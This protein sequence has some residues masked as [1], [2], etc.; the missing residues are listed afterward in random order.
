MA[1]V[2]TERLDGILLITLNRP[3]VRNAVNAALARGVADAL[4]ELD[5]DDSLRVGIL[6]GAGGTFCSG[7]DLG[8]LLQGDNPRIEGRGF[9]GVV[10][11]G[12]VK[13]LIA[14]VEGYAVAGGFEVALACDIIV[15]GRGAKFGL[16][17]VRRGLTPAGGGVL[18]LPQRL[19]YYVAMEL[20]FTGN[21]I[22][23]DRA[24]SFGLVSDLVETGGAV[25]RAVEI[26]RQIVAN[27]PLSVRAIK[28]IVAA[29]PDWPT[30]RAFELQSPITSA[31]SASDDARE[32]ARAF[33][34]KRPAVWTGR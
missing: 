9:A 12:S 20:L 34:E 25:D 23:A 31:V 4:D 18:R 7:M 3:E 10:Q 1:E 8:A 2:E 27:A 24:Y 33:K 30:D 19:P 11:R 29:S 13:P 26:A 6:T 32:G 14:A 21:T 17:E 15:A 22:D 5:A 16:P 28:E